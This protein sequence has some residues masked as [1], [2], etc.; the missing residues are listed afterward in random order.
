MIQGM[1]ARLWCSCGLVMCIGVLCLIIMWSEK[2]KKKE[3]IIAG[4]LCIALGLGEGIWHSYAL[5]HPQEQTVCAVFLYDQKKTD[6]MPLLPSS[7]EYIFRTEQGK[8]FGLYMD[9]YVKKQLVSGALEQDKTYR[10]TYE[11]RTDLILEIQNE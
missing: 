11:G 5:L 1:L 3:M 7:R 9:S 4:C 6:V 8:I 2:E 10:V